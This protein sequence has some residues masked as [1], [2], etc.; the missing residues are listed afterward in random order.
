MTAR[1]GKK[2][3][4]HVSTVALAP[5]GNRP[6]GTRTNRVVIP[7]T[8]V[9]RQ[10]RKSFPRVIKDGAGVRV[11]HWA[12]LWGVTPQ[13]GSENEA[14]ILVWSIQGINQAFS[15]PTEHLPEVKKRM[16]AVFA[17]YGS[18]AT[19]LHINPALKS[20]DLMLGSEPSLPKQEAIL[21]MIFASSEWYDSAT[22]SNLA[23]FSGSNP[24][25]QPNKWKKSGKLFALKRGNTDM[26]PSY[27]FGDDF[28]PLP[29]M[30]SILN[31]F[32]DKKSDFKI[33]A[34]F[35]SGNSWLRNKR[36]LDLIG[37]DPDA[38]I[39]AAEIE[40]SPIDHG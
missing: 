8:Q 14:E 24:S 10:P 13:G 19:I 23:G 21:N 26:Y 31:V 22:L 2:T 15:I 40:V 29:A 28:R 9:L 38:V 33:A 4:K 16:M 36:P 32:D 12:P 20:T 6:A 3:G 7:N 5:S 1:T 18:P 11:E 39:K 25:A 30:K 17:E 34:W 27:A 37:T 35:S